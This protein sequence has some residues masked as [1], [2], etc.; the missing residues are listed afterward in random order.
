MS[1]EEKPVV[2]L[3]QGGL[4]EIWKTFLDVSK[5]DD[6]PA[7]LGVQVLHSRAPTPPECTDRVVWYQSSL[8]P[9]SNDDGSEESFATRITFK[10]KNFWEG[11][12]EKFIKTDDRISI[13][14]YGFD[15]AEGMTLQWSMNHEHCTHPHPHLLYS[16][17]AAGV[18]AA[19]AVAR[20]KHP[21]DTAADIE[22]L[23]IGT[24]AYYYQKTASM[25]R[26]P[27]IALRQPERTIEKVADTVFLAS[28]LLIPPRLEIHMQVKPSQ[29]S[30]SRVQLQ[31]SFSG[32]DS[33]HV[34]SKTKHLLFRELTN[35]ALSLNWWVGM[36]MEILL[37]FEVPLKRE[38]E[39]T[40]KNPARKR[41]NN[42]FS[43][44]E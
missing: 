2:Q 44:I 9:K 7:T 43:A 22:E 34:D 39:K 6:L 15:L 29:R 8:V 1:F 17:R 32:V 36:N 30:D 42:F 18:S 16:A 10:M 4:T 14:S 19:E 21:R 12:I 23:G 11:V 31:V 40:R 20:G 38:S 33:L 5:E 26:D 41:V 37:R 35:Y 27:G 24:R 28:H 25:F 3:V 13:Y